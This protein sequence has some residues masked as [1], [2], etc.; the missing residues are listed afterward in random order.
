[1]CSSPRA[2]SRHSL[3]WTLVGAFVLAQATA[4]ALKPLRTPIREPSRSCNAPQALRVGLFGF[5]D[6]SFDTVTASLVLCS[7]ASPSLTLQEFKRVLRPGGRLRLMEHV[8]SDHWLAGPLMHVSNPIWVRINR[9]GCSW[10]RR[11]V[12]SVREAGFTIRSI[13][14]FKIFSKAVAFTGPG[15]IIKADLPA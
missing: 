12:E 4:C 15:R 14:Q 3:L 8:R 9:M 10:N 7:V 13:A 11:T 1:M 5:D 6:S 2:R